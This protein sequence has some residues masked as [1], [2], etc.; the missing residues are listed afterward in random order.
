M[1]I[2]ILLKKTQR[3]KA[4]N[5]A[6][7]GTEGNMMSKDREDILKATLISY[8]N[9]HFQIALIIDDKSY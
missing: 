4:A 8:W 7:S 1:E 6:H 9:S 5:L 3:I 2:K